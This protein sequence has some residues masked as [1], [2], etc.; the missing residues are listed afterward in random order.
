MHITS[1]SRQPGVNA[2]AE[3]RDRKLVVRLRRRLE[4]AAFDSLR[5]SC[6][7]AQVWKGRSRCKVCVKLLL[8]VLRSA[9][10][11][12][13]DWA[14]SPQRKG[15]TML[16]NRGTRPSLRTLADTTSRYEWKNDREEG[17]SEVE[18]RFDD[19]GKLAAVDYTMARVAAETDHVH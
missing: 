14:A 12:L 10:L 7:V 18:L 4:I 16:R 13:S 2:A 8:E 11:K 6:P 19:Q 5:R 3:S 9:R 1:Q 15:S 17:F